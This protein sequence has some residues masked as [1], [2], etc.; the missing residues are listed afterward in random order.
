MPSTLGDFRLLR[1][2]GRGGMGIVYEAIE[3]PLN[4]RVALKVLDQRISSDPKSLQRFEREA[5]AVASLHHTN[6]IRS[7]RSEVKV[8][9]TTT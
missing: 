2:A 8:M 9:C 4:R 1:E 6:I 5:Q 7:L 3:V